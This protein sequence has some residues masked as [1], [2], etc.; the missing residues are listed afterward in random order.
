MNANARTLLLL[1]ASGGGCSARPAPPALAGIVYNVHDFVTGTRAIVA[2]RED[3]AGLPVQLSRPGVDTV[4]A[5]ALP[6][7]RALLVERAT[8]GHLTGFV[9]VGADGLVR[10]SLGEPATRDYVGVHTARVIEDRILVELARADAGPPD[11]FVLAEGTPPT[12]VQ[13]GAALVAQAGPGLLVLIGAQTAAGRGQLASVPLSGG[14]ARMLGD[15]AGDDAAVAVAGDRALFAMSTTGVGQA[16]LVSALDGDT[17]LARNGSADAKVVAL[18]MDSA[19]GMIYQRGDTIWVTGDA[20]DR[21]LTR[22]NFVAATQSDALVV[23]PTFALAAFPLHGAGP[24]RTL[25]PQVGEAFHLFQVTETHVL[26]RV[27]VTGTPELRAAPVTSGPARSL[28]LR[29]GFEVW[30][31]A[32]TPD[33]HVLAQLTPQAESDLPGRGSELWSVRLAGDD[34]TRVAHQIDA[35][36]TEEATADQDFEALTP[37]GRLILEVEYQGKVAGSQLCA[38][39][40]AAASARTVSDLGAVQFAGLLAE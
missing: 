4:F 34:L 15:T 13:A 29:E 22:G 11:L 31:P 24:A 12:L 39:G 14:P 18:A 27:E 8:D 7:G 10:A 2:A 25:D 19:S 33:G 16:R 6:E 21:Q 40:P 30:A 17:L 38:G 9:R 20:G 35:G 3:G 36:A 28:L 37:A 1:L 32:V 23:T 26:Y 5:S